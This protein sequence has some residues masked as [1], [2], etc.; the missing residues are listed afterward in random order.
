M[1]ILV[2]TDVTVWL[3]ELDASGLT[4]QV[5][6]GGAAEVKDSTTF[7]TDGWRT[8]LPGLKTLEFTYAGFGEFSAGGQ[9]DFDFDNLGSN[10]VHTISPDGA[11]GSVAYSFLGVKSS[12]KKTDQLGEI[13]AIEGMAQN[14]RHGAIRGVIL[15][16]KTTVTGDTSGTGVQLGDVA[17]T[18]KLYVAIHVFTAGTTADIIV[19]SDNADTFGSATTRTSTTV[20][21]TGG[22]WVTPV[23]GAITDD[24]WRVRTANVTGSFSIAVS[25]GIA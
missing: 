18:E 20:S 11:D 24:W 14:A 8:F 7:T 13:H 6:L 4:N 23:S 12:Y 17:A 9:D 16:P 2:L 1:S 5:G 3:D 21:A 10:V 19:E 25:V 15:K 22:T